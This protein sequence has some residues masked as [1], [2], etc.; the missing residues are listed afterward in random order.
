M[1]TT[2][3]TQAPP[4]D[5]AP[6]GYYS[7]RDLRDRWRC[8]RTKLYEL[9]DSPAFPCPVIVGRTLLFPCHEVWAWEAAELM[10]EAASDAA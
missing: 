2:T 3:T 6:H 4:A 8:G 1:T 7:T 10:T 9:I 5:P